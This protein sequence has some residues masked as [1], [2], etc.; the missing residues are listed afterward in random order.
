MTDRIGEEG[1]HPSVLSR[2]ERKMYEA[3][4]KQA[5]DLFERSLKEYEKSDNKYQKAE[6]KKVMEE[7]L[8]VLNDSARELRRKDLLTQNSKIQEDYAM[9]KEDETKSS[10]L[11]TDLDKA[12]HSI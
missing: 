8:Q 1:D 12:K 5:A 11:W 3:E 9:F 2:Q 7:S 10:Q 4:Y 6:F